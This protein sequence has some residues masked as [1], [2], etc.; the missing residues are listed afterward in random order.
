MSQRIT[1][2]L[3]KVS[4]SIFLI[5][6]VLAALLPFLNVRVLRMA[7]DEKVYLSQSIEMARN[8]NW[9]VQTLAGEPSYFKG[10][11]HYILVRIGMIVFGNRIIAGT[12]MNCLFAILTGLALYH[13]GRKRWNDKSALLLGVAA[14]LNVGIVSHVYVSQMEVEVCAFYALAIAA[15]GLATPENRKRYDLAFWV[16]AGLAGWSKSP[17]HSVLISA[18]GLCYWTLTNQLVSRLRTS[19]FWL[20]GFTGAFIGLAGYLPAYFADKP[21]FVETFIMREQFQKAHNN[22]SWT[23]V[24]KPLFHFALPWTFII[25]YGL[26]KLVRKRK[27]FDRQMLKLGAAM[28]LPTLLFWAVWSYKGQNYNLPALSAILLF[29]WGCFNGNVPRGA[30]RAAG[31]LA[32]LALIALISVIGHFWPLP[33]WWGF[34][35]VLLAFGAMSLHVAIFLFA[36]DLRV[37]CV[38]AAAFFIA[39]GAIIAPLGKRE[40]IDIKSFV[41]THPELIY[42]YYDLDPSIW[43][44]WSLLQLTV[45][46]TIYGLHKPTQLAEATKPGH[47]VLVQNADWQNVVL[48]YWKKNVQSS[49]SKALAPV[50]TTWSRW[51]TKGTTS[52]GQSHWK[53]AWESRDLRQLERD[54]TIIW[55]Q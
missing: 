17:L 44:E 51:L 12:W 37:L 1:S 6:V 31:G 27:I 33:Q 39:F 48:D 47:V 13:L 34:G 8:G 11:L 4:G 38:G 19:E 20:S 35:W 26:V 14:A 15:L 42:H 2:Y 49:N 25:L 22:R 36:E 53:I 7:G 54:F 32:L 10:P 9:F 41:K 29:A 50:I 52:E 5:L 30:L 21:N 23:Y 28:A 18:G 46:H 45:H 43:S 24:T 55:F 3:Y 40:M 16:F